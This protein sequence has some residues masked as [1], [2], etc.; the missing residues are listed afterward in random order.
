MVDTMNLE[1]LTQARA[2]L[3]ADRIE[4]MYA[5]IGEFG[6]RYYRLAAGLDG[7]RVTRAALRKIVNPY[8]IQQKAKELAHV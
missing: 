6:R 8:S 2:L 1:N 7:C 4:D 3:E 5:F